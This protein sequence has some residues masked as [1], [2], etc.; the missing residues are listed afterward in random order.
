MKKIY[1][2]PK[3]R[4]YSVH[5]SKMIMTSNLSR[6]TDFKSGTFSGDTK[7]ENQENISLWDLY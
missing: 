6:G 5:P 4:V 3:S 7:E 2:K 1:N